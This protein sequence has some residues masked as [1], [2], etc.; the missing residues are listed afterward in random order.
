MRT[1]GTVD[2]LFMRRFLRR[3]VK[4]ALGILITHNLVTFELNR[5]GF[6]DYSISVPNILARTRFERY[7]YCA[8]KLYGDDRLTHHS[9]SHCQHMLTGRC[10]TDHIAELLVE[11]ILCHGQIMTSQLLGAVVDKLNHGSDGMRDLFIFVIL[12]GT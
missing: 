4:K 11:E 2:L 6:V 7:I 9:F 1:H 3:Q 8:Q 12:I 10:I 5:L